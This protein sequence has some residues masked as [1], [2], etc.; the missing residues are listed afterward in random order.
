[1]FRLVGRLW[2]GLKID[3]KL[4]LLLYWRLCAFELCKFAARKPISIEMV[5]ELVS[6][7]SQ[8]KYTYQTLFVMLNTIER[9]IV[10]NDYLWPFIC[11]LCIIS[12]CSQFMCWNQRTA[13]NV[14]TKQHIQNINR[15]MTLTFQ[16]VYFSALI[17]PSNLWLR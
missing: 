6:Q 2:I 10:R 15:I 4:D 1:M 13:I 12:K 8:R 9:E 3:H 16:G 7:T 11:I 14:R 17:S 5:Y